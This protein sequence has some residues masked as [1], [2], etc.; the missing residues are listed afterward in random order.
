M[1]DLSK[2]EIELRRFEQFK[3]VIGNFPEGSVEPSEEPDFLVRTSSGTIGIELTE[4]H[5]QP[6]IGQSPKQEQQAMRKRVVKRAQAIY[7]KENPLPVTAT[8][9]FNDHFR[10]HKNEVESLAQAIVKIVIRNYPEENFRHQEEKRY[11]SKDKDNFPQ[12]IRS[13]STIR[14]DSID[15]IFFT[16]IEADWELP[17]SDADIKRI[18]KSKESK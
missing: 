2:K 5:S 9:A 11:R 15:E 16:C 18:L 12:L 4:L 3:A 17:L 14:F 13:V 7:E 8:I 10:I 1:I 6:P